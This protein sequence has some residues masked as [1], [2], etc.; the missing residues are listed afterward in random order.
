ML[1]L[2][3]QKPY[4]LCV[5]EGKRVS[6]NGGKELMKEEMSWRTHGERCLNWNTWSKAKEGGPIR[7]ERWNVQIFCAAVTFFGR[8]K[9]KGSKQNLHLWRSYLLNM[10]WHGFWSHL[11]TITSQCA[12]V[13]MWVVRAG[14]VHL[15]WATFFITAWM[16][17]TITLIVVTHSLLLTRL[18]W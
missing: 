11:K 16:L 2:I 10:V 3:L 15:F 4:L 14:V 9:S 18:R 8:S 7:V 13:Q 1:M 6:I 17:R 5:L 12:N